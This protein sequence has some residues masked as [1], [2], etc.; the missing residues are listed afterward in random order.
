MDQTAA[1][2]PLRRLLRYSR[3]HRGR[4]RLAVTCSVLNKV[5]DLGHLFECKAYSLQV[6]TKRQDAIGYATHMNT[7]LA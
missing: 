5:F 1:E 2:G 3:A 4:L 6:A 7:F